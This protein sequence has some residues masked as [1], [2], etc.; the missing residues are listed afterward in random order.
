MTERIKRGL[1]R[2]K[3]WTRRAPKYLRTRRMRRAGI[4]LLI[5]LTLYTIG[6]FFGLPMVLRHILTNQVAASLKRPV[7]VGEITVNPFRLK[8]GVDHLQIAGRD[9]AKPFVDV[10]RL[11]VKLSWSSLWRLAP[12]I[13]HLEIDR[14]VV[15]VV[16]SG[17]QQFNF[18]DLLE[19]T[20]PP[21]PPGKPARFALYNIELR[22]GDIRFDDQVLGKRHAVEHIELDLPFIANMPAD[23]KIFVRPLLRM[24]VDGSP[25]KI[26]GRALPFAN[27][28]ESVIGLRLDHLN[29]VPLI[30]YV[31][32]KLPVTIPH[33]EL[34]AYLQVHFAQAAAGPV[35]RVN[36]EVSLDQLE[37]RDAA[38]APLVGIQRFAAILDDIQPLNRVFHLGAITANGLKVSLMRNRNGTTNLTPL[39]APQPSAAAP[40]P[41]RSAPAAVNSP[42]AAAS[43]AATPEASP[44][45]TPVPSAV[46]LA[47]AAAAPTPAAPA[48]DAAVSKPAPAATPAKPGTSTPAATPAAAVKAG[49]SIAAPSIAAAAPAARATPV[50][51]APASHAKE[52]PLDLTI[53]SLAITNSAVKLTDDSLATPASLTLQNINVGLKQ[54]ALGAKASP[55]AY[56]FSG[57]LGGGGSIAV[58]GHLDLAQSQVTSEI[59]L[60]QVNLPALQAYGHSVLAATVGAGKLSAHATVQT[61]FATKRFNLHVEPA[62][63]SVD[64]LELAA[65]GEKQQPVRWTQFGATVAM[66]DLATHQA[67]V[68]EVHA[69]GIRLFVK[70]GRD[71]K[72]SLL[73]LLSAPAAPGSNDRA[74]ASRTTTRKARRRTP[75]RAIVSRGRHQ[76]PHSARHLARRAKAHAPAAPSG[77]AAAQWRYKIASIKIDKVSLEAEDDAG[78]RPM[79]AR[80][81][82]LNLSASNFTSDFHQP[83][84]IKI[85]GVLDRRGSFKLSGPV[86]I[87]PLK[88]DLRVQTGR[89]NLALAENYLPNDLNATIKRALLTSNGVASAAMVGDKLRMR[90][91]GDA[92]LNNVR[93]LDKLTGDDFVRWNSLRFHRID[94]GLGQGKPRVHVGT[95][96]LADFYARIILNKDGRLNLSDLTSHPGQAPKS[97]TREETPTVPPTAQPAPVAAA[98]PPAPEP[99]GADI[100]LGDIMLSGGHVD[101]SDLFIKPNYR[102]NLTEIR[103]KVGA[104]GTRATTPA[105]VV[106][107][108]QINDS[109][110][111]HIGGTINP[112]A[113]LAAVDLKAKAD[114]IELTRLTAYSVKYTGYPITKGSLTVNVHYVLANQVLTADNHIFLDQL[115]FGDKVPSPTAMNLPMRL[116]VAILKDS[117]G[118]INLDVPVSGSLN[119]PQ[120]SLGSVIL[121]A[122]TGIVTKAVT[123]PF[124]L[125]A[126]AIGGLAGANAKDLSY[127]EFAPGRAILTA[128]S[129]KRLDVVAAALNARP[130]LKLSIS[131]RV[132]PAVDRPGLHEAKV[133][134]LVRARLKESGNAV[135]ADEKIPPDLYDKYLKRVYKAAKFDK[136]TD[137][138]G[139][140]KSLPPAEMKK[141]L[142]EHM[143]VSDNDLQRLADARAQAVRHYLSTK[144][145]PS[146]LF[147]VASRLDASGIDDKG[148]ATRADLSLQ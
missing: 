15:H 128:D 66:V 32:A 98:P 136:P 68:K 22:D 103:G 80:I 84:D 14:P 127:V 69:D 121:H 77:P 79:K 12:V 148:K 92:I 107:D 23:T 51:P 26:G 146:R 73:S 34:S 35:I 97:L 59:T 120:F 6:G 81:F 101:Y 17:P 8:L 54:F 45:A 36:G 67:V 39:M 40:V 138:L 16:R 90:Y 93:L 44:A 126:G 56:D 55:A 132:D 58:K 27:Q 41:Q 141:L 30:G 9:A 75:A 19:P 86:T 135:S 20:T 61:T 95:I 43:P 106:I 33:G 25:V 65:P 109:A 29:L 4:T 78:Q 42:V 133:D 48:T 124:R 10:E 52:S 114:G 117:N 53:A 113:P 119:D 37:V 147:T 88:A 129:R 125:L 82:P 3:S 145:E 1:E 60:D 96:T 71:G 85:D 102:A 142:V 31:P 123:A 134:D 2:I 74:T 13:T 11:R 89:L 5:V 64:N 137:F 115:T 7:A 57:T 110:P 38:D 21:P 28:P 70:R 130:A 83:F 105:Y 50:P 18:S 87:A 122:F 131:G 104:F 139:L 63:F 144:V 108:G 46:P 72:L 24:V 49:P 116:A 111:I 91:R 140:N 94:F 100:E 143:K 99:I 118:Q 62:S 112:L 47:K 76:R